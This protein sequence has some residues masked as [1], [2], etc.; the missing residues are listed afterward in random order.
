MSS[1]SKKHV[2]KKVIVRDI[3]ERKDIPESYLGALDEN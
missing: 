2:N 1:R 3:K